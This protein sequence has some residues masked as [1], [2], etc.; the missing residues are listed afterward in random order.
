ME[1][2]DG[3]RSSPI[4]GW[5][6]QRWAAL[7]DHMLASVRPFA[8]PGHGRIT[9]PGVEGGYG[10]AIDGLEGFA[11]TLL[12]AGFRLAGENGHDPHGYAEWYSQGIAAGVDQSREDRWITLP[13]HGQAKVEAALIALV[14]DMTRPWIWDRL[15]PLT[16]EQLVTYLSS[17]VGDTDYPRN[18]W[19]WFR[20]VVQTFLKS[21]G[22][23]WSLEDMESDLAVH[24]SFK[25]ADG[26]FS[27]GDERSFDYYAGWALHLYPTL[28]ARMEGAQ[29][30]AGPR[31]AEEHT[32]L[33]RFLQDYVKL[34]GADGAPLIQ[35][36]SLAYRFA[37]AAPLW[38]GAIAEVPSVDSG[39]LR[40]AASGM[41][42]YF[43]R[44]EVPD[45]RGL[46]TGGWFHE[47]LPMLQSYSGT[48]SPYWASKGLLGLALPADHPAWTAVEQP[49]P[50]DAGDVLD[51]VGP[52]GW[53]VSGT[54]SDGIVRVINHGTDH[55]CEGDQTGD[56]PLYAR[57]G[58]STATWPWLDEPS[59]RQPSEQSVS[60]VDR[61]ERVSHRA[62]WAP[63]APQIVDGGGVPVAVGGS[64]VD[65]HWIDMPVTQTRHASG[66]VGQVIP[67]GRLAIVSL[68]RGPW[69]LR[70]VNVTSLV[71]GVT[72][73]EVTLRITGWPTVAGDDLSSCLQPVLGEAR[74]S[75]HEREQCSPMGPGASVPRLELPV[76]T[77]TWT[78]ALVTLARGSCP[79]EPV[80]LVLEP[81]DTSE[82]AVV[83][84]PDGLVTRTE[85]PT[86]L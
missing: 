48:G 74:T 20:L 40:R 82:A 71:D 69:E 57:I 5:D 61:L 11:R 78:A 23:P 27:D 16:Q 35:G 15:S 76:R 53:I 25:R 21:V 12:M 10:R 68:V 31:M 24:D 4:T 83:T 36:R 86:Q 84:W 30:L 81:G 17:V 58:Y 26:W 14:L 29:E 77:G 85:L 63:I 51:V 46:L 19:C 47:W 28:W 67:A 62:G 42:D 3:H 54:T 9:L 60:L 75:V 44:H 6:R 39:L 13:E 66:W 8:S 79:G 45:E 1:H 43:G 37:T 2:S 50:V 33:D 73:G 55:A 49:L 52:P 65:A 38:V 64:L 32:R 80:T 56:S 34:I 18:N 72:A 7:A 59:W 70:L 41:V 22:G